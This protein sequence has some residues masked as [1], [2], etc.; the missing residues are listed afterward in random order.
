MSFSG[1][2]TYTGGSSLPEI[3][4]DVADLV[5]ILGPQETPFLD[6]LGDPLYSATSTRHEWLE[7]SLISNTTTIN[8]PSISDGALNVTAV[9]VVNGAIFRIGDLVKGAG[10]TEVLLVTAV[11]GNVITVTR[12]YGGSTKAQLT[13][14]EVLVILGNAALEAQDAGTPRFTVRTRQ[15]N[16]TQIFS[17]ALQISG[18]EMAVRQLAVDDELD[19][20]KTLRLREL[21]RDLENTVVNGVGPAA[22]P[23]GSATVRRTMRGLIAS[24]TTNVM[25]PGAG[26]IPG[27]SSLGEG[28]INGALQTIWEVSGNK[29]DL[30]L[31]GGSQKRR[32][33]GFIQTN[34]R[35]SP[36]GEQ[37]KNL[38]STYESDYGVCRVILSRYVP[39]DAVIFVDSSKAA[40]VP[41]TGRSFG[42]LALAATGDYV[43]GELVGEYTFE[44]RH[45]KGHGILRGLA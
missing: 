12:G 44:L 24:L 16:Y 38:V 45:E 25:T 41:L 5:T 36:A 30:I 20:Q 2:A 26:H 7:D 22:T 28:H 3:A 11:S 18:T 15:S 34:Q 19:Y 13:D 1:K 4:E 37:F 6:A 10:S 39:A 35:F 29:P 21:L 17:T 32:I 23:E 33:N 31:C 8:E 40:V 43:S 42:Y 27:D 9:T 14:T